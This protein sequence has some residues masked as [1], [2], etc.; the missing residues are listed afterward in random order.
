[1]YKILYGEHCYSVPRDIYYASVDESISSKEFELLL[2]TSNE[3]TK[4]Y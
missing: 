1:M 3:I 2:E 4:I